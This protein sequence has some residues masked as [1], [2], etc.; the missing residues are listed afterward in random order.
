[1]STAELILTIILF[2]IAFAMFLLSYLQF[3]EKMVLINNAWLY[4]SKKERET[5]NKTPHYRQ[6]GVV[7]VLIGLNFLIDAIGCILHNTDL[8][9]YAVIIICVIAVIYAIVSSVQIEKKN[10][11]KSRNKAS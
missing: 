1:M 8:M 3:K 9:L 2:V 11:Q 7:F 4:A 6:S 5:M 10:K